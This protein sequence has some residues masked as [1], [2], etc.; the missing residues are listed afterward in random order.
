MML[1]LSNGILITSAVLLFIV[2]SVLTSN[3]VR[4]LLDRIN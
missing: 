1:T 2:Y 3:K 4:P